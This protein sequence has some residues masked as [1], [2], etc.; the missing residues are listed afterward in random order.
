MTKTTFVLLATTLFFAAAS[1]RPLCGNN[2][3]ECL[4]AN[5]CDI[6]YKS[7]PVGGRCS[8]A[9]QPNCL[10]YYENNC[11]RCAEGYAA[12]GSRCISGT[13]AN[14]YQEA[15]KGGVHQCFKCRNGYPSNDFSSCVQI[16]NPIANC[17]VGETG[18]RGDHG[19]AVCTSGYTS[20]SDKNCIRTTIPGCLE[21]NVIGKCVLCD[22]ANG[23]FGR[24]S[25]ID[26][27]CYRNDG[28]QA[29]AQKR[30]F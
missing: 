4:G 15:V 6:C 1:Q 23:W 20:N 17:V 28:V 14:C 27:R 16:S 26:G 18:F 2:C 8:G 13:I 21:I 24:G 25:A 22:A 19:C 7:V 12:E 5:S 9:A 3:L 29:T 11:D 10:V 30:L